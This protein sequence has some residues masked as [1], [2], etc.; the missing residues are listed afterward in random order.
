M[1]HERTECALRA[2]ILAKLSPPRN[3]LA[4]LLPG[5]PQPGRGPLEQ[6]L[7]PIEWACGRLL[8]LD[9]NSDGGRKCILTTQKFRSTTQQGGGV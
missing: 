9:K 4:P 8:P 7:H 3:A 2:P 6:P 5:N 1:R